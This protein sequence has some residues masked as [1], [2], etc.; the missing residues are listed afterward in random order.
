[1]IVLQT[2]TRARLIGYEDKIPQLEKMLTYRN[3]ST[4]FEYDRVLQGLRTFERIKYKIEENQGRIY[5]TEKLKEKQERLDELKNLVKCNLLFKD[6]EGLWI[7]SGAAYK[8][9]EKFNDTVK[10]EYTLPE[11][12]LMSWATKPQ[13]D[14]RPYQEQ[15][16]EILLENSVKGPCAIEFATGAGKTKILIEIIKKTG[17]EALVVTPSTSIAK[18]MLAELSEVFGKQTVGLYGATKKDFDKRVTIA[19]DDSLVALPIDSEAYAKLAGKKLLVYD[20]AHTSSSETL[21][22]VCFGLM[23][24]IPLRFFLSATVMRND[25]SDKLL[26]GITG[27]VVMRKNLKDL[28]DEGYLAKPYFKMV[29]VRSNSNCN[30]KDANIMTRHHTYYNK[31]LNRLAADFANK[32]VNLMKRP[33]LILVEELEQFMYLLPHFDPKL[34]VRFAHGPISKVNRGIIPEEYAK[35]KPEDLVDEFNKGNID[36]LVGT[37]CISMGTD[38]RVCEAGIYLM[39]KTS[40]IKVRQSLGRLTRGGEKSNVIN[41]MTGIKKKDCIYIDFCVKNVTVLENH[42]KKRMAIYNEAYPE[43][44]QINY[45]GV[46]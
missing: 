40:E 8:I 22:K 3:K 19:I 20:E 12:E 44:E 24:N 9:A 32:F 16:V 28:V 26:E 29:N 38:L 18:Q 17:L 7:Y 23:K 13:Y 35:D 42:A 39:G 46:L 6:Q 10:V 45:M 30:S 14:L 15:A 11:Y 25:G 5:Y 2:P 4:E 33:T 34:R 27:P 21:E 1:M 36:I 37:S 41:P 31:P 43:V